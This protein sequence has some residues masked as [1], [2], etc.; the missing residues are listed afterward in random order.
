MDID[1][2][3]AYLN[4][5]GV[6]TTTDVSSSMLDKT[7]FMEMLVVQMQNQ[8]PL[9]PMDNSEMTAQLA[10]LSSL[11]QLDNL[12]SSFEN[13]QQSA[14]SAISLMNSGQTVELELTDGSVVT[15]TLDKVKWSDSETQ[16][17]INGDT[18]SAGSVVSMRP[19]VAETTES[20]T[21]DSSEA[22]ES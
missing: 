20:E 7:T 18:Y 11:E 13:F 3:R 22:T 2:I 9:E 10:Q 6:E 21:D 1:S 19:I 8:D 17:V 15:G 4:T 16:F 5:S 12:N 14:T